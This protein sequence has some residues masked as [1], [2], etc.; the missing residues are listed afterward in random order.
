MKLWILLR[1]NKWISERYCDKEY[2]F[3]IVSRELS[4]VRREKTPKPK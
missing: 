3:P 4:E 2:E 1:K